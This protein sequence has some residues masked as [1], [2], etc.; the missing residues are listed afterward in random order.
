MVEWG[1]FEGTRRRY[2]REAEVTLAQEQEWKRHRNKGPCLVESR[3]HRDYV[4]GGK[5]NCIPY[6][7]ALS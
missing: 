1:M 2:S 3:V 7:S 6:S 5:R 4:G